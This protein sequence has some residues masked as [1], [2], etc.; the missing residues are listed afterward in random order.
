MTAKMAGSR[1]FTAACVQMQGTRSVDRNIEAAVAL[2]R[3]A[4]KRGVDYVQTP[5]QTG[6]ME[7]QRAKLFESITDE[8]N[9]KALAVFRKLAAELGIWLHVGSLAI[10]VSETQGANRAFVIDPQGVIAA[11]YDKIHMFDVDLPNGE[12]YRESATY[13]SG[14]AAVVA[15]LPWARLGLSICYDIR[16]PYLYRALAKA[17]ATVL[18]APAAFTKVTGEAHWHLLQ[19]AR[20][21]ENGA[22]LISA[23]QGGMHEN[24][25]ATYGHSLIVAPWGEVLAEAGTEPEVIVAEIDL[26][27]VEEARGRVP[28]LTHDR[29]FQPPVE[30]QERRAS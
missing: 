12:T 15:D 23:A 26:A 4:A 6:I 10:R 2:I 30:T 17:G 16:F 19:R 22:F 21:V 7:L 5:E 20:A 24:G 25:R 11:R 1:K 13:R 29:T 8:E 14:T 9:D 27:K 28:S 18:S 3:E